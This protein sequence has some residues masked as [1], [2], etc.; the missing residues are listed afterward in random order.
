M[1]K[2]DVLQYLKDN[3]YIIQQ[4]DGYIITNKFTRE[5]GV[6]STNPEP[7]STQSKVVLRPAVATKEVYKQFISDA[8]V[9][10]FIYSG[11][12]QKF[13]ANRYSE[14]AFKVFKKV[15]DD[16][17]TNRQVLLASTKWYYKQPNT[18]KVMI[19]T[20]FEKGI[21]ES[22][23]DDFVRAANNKK[24]APTVEDNTKNSLRL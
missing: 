4:G 11:N 19:S 9:P 22:C 6:S 1:I 20:Y 16:V 14:P 2:E 23:Y 8:G 24:S 7:T 17:K 15:W 21:W 13:F 18:T 12:G 3:L 10:T 5:L